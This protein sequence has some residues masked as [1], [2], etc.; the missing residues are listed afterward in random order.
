MRDN[1]GI[2]RPGE[3]VWTVAQAARAAVLVDAAATFGAMRTAMLK[4]RRRILVVGWD[5]DTRTPLVGEEYDPRDG[6][7]RELGPFLTALVERRPGLRIDLLLWDYALLFGLERELLPELRLDWATPRQIRARLDDVL[8]I[9]AS[10]HQ[11]IV[12]VDGA[13]AFS[14]GLDLAIRRWDTRA[15][16]L[17]DPRRRDPDGGTYRPFHDVQMVVDGAAAGALAALAEARWRQAEGGYAAAPALP[18][19]SPPQMPRRRPAQPADLWPEDVAPDFRDI[20]IGIARTR[21]AFAGVPAIREVEAL[22]LAAIAAAE[23]TIYIENQFLTRDSVVQALI[24]RMRAVGALEAL[25]VAPNVHQSWLE[26]HSMNAGR[27]RFM[28]LLREAG[29][30]ER[31]RLVYPALADDPTGEG[32][33]VHAKLMIVDDRL[34][35]VGSANL[36]NRSMGL[37]TECDLAIEARTDAERAAVARI[38]DG[39]VA[40]HHGV[41]PEAIAR[42]FAR[43][44]SLLAALDALPREGRRLAPIDLG[45]PL[46]SGLDGELARRIGELADPETPIATPA[47]GGEMV[48]GQPAQRALART[49]RLVLLGGAIIAVVALWRLSPAAQLTDPSAVVARL[50]A[51]GGGSL[52]PLIVVAAF[53]LGGFVV[54]PVTVL[55]AG[56]GMMFPP[57]TA[58]AVAA[59]GVLLSAGA[60]YLVGRALG[61][62][63]LERRM[64]RRARD[65]SRALA[66]RGVI[67]VAA[68]RMLPLAPFTLVNLVVGASR[69]GIVDYLIG[70]ALG[71]APGLVM[72]TLLGTQL[73]EVLASPE[74]RELALL[75]LA[76]AAWLG[77]SLGLQVLVYRLKKRR[78]RRAERRAPAEGRPPGA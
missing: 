18:K 49:I 13:L 72:L 40:E 74:P 73:A 48:A 57:A 16:A 45:P 66:D 39:L 15:H 28:T 32:V 54:F 4:A 6:L 61:R 19:A 52:A 30:A 11:K 10:H 37:D 1:G 22:F 20:G 58:L 75:G 9:G 12:V 65:I 47:F 29:L 3:T 43:T 55:I 35:R 78:R 25:L 23:R 59:A 5:I 27:R 36:N 31:A 60:T 7:P 64:G 42:A 53:V 38:R 67:A 34:L 77:L 33:M 62:R 71:M 17:A 56:T 26:E 24:A 68:L 50:E 69:I 76:V 44:G 14:G 2:L 41:A 21:P 51:L 8:P 70:T 46:G 63:A